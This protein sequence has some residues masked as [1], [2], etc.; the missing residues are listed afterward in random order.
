MCEGV[1][2][3]EVFESIDFCENL[4][5]RDAFESYVNVKSDT[6]NCE[7]AEMSRPL[8]ARGGRDWKSGRPEGGSRPD[9]VAYVFVF[10]DS[11]IICPLYKLTLSD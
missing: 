10:L 8:L 11:V 7:A 5:E 2:S 9:Y 1:S 4:Y 6:Q 3:V